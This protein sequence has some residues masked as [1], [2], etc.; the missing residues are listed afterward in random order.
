MIIVQSNYRRKNVSLVA[1]LMEREAAVSQLCHPDHL[2]ASGVVPIASPWMLRYIQGFHAIVLA[3]GTWAEDHVA[4]SWVVGPFGNA[5]MRFSSSV[6]RQPDLLLG[7]CYFC[8][9]VLTR[10]WRCVDFRTPFTAPRFLE[11]LLSRRKGR[12]KHRL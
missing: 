1:S 4:H 6:P 7:I 10:A 11:L 12:G 5:L 8:S 3:S 9:V 2:L